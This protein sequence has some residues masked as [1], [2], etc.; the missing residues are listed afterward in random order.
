[1]G[2]LDSSELFKSQKK[3]IIVMVFSNVAKEW[4]RYVT[5]GLAKFMP[6]PLFF[7]LSKDLR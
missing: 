5:L 4:A 7:C 6:P 1:M 3:K 2:Q